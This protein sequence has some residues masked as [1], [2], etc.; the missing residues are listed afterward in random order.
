MAYLTDLRKI[1]G[2]SFDFG[3]SDLIN[4]TADADTINIYGGDDQ[5]IAGDGDDIIF[6]V[7]SYTGG[8]SGRDIVR[9]GFG[10]DLIVS[11]LD[12]SSNLYDGG[13]GIDT[14]NFIPNSNG[15]R[16]RPR[17]GN[18]DGPRNPGRLL[19]HLHR[20][21][22]RHRRNGLHSSVTATPTGSRATTATT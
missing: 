4:G 3:T 9:G 20:E 13:A 11:S 2:I 17:L 5:V 8:L 15:V 6:D 22:R 10:N 16:R 1:L 7:R 21:C 12:T 14:V 19:P 18:G